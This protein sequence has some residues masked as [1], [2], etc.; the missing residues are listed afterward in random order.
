[1][2]TAVSASQFT[3]LTW[4]KLFDCKT[5][6]RDKGEKIGQTICLGPKHDNSKR[7]VVKLL[8]F[9]KVLVNRDQD[10]EAPSHGVKQKAIIKI[11]PTHFRGCSYLVGRQFL[12]KTSWHTTIKK[13][14]HTNYR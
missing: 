1:M 6:R 10:I 11:T 13:N 3:N 5:K 2:D 14:P 12:G 4:P 7:P 8:L 9:R